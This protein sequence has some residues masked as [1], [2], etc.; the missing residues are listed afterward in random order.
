M[1]YVITSIIPCVL[2]HCHFSEKKFSLTKNMFL[3]PL[4]PYQNGDPLIMCQCQPFSFMAVH[5]Q[6]YHRNQYKNIIAYIYFL[7]SQ[8]FIL[9]S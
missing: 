2:T 3:R 8:L 9:P 7:R 1:H 5:F 6:L 4:L